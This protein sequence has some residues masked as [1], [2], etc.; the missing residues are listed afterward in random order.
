MCNCCAGDVVGEREL[1]INEPSLTTATAFGEHTF[2]LLLDAAEFHS[3]LPAHKKSAAGRNWP[4]SQQDNAFSSL[5]AFSVKARVGQGAFAQVALVRHSGTGKV[6]A[7]KRMNRAHLESE[8][9]VKQ[10]MNERYARLGGAK[11]A[12]RKT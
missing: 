6:Y 3:L 9:V 2:C 1:L 5:T 12:P 8:K 10:V 11:P 7:L 4:L